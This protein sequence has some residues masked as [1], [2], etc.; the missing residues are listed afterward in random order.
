[1]KTG[2]DYPEPPVFDGY[3]WKFS[4]KHF[5]DYFYVPI[6]WEC[7]RCHRIN[8]PAARYCDCKPKFKSEIDDDTDKP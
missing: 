5:D 8:A 7:P 6:P 1:M 4:S 2:D 3:K